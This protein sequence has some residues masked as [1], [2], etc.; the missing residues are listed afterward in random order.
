MAF[1]F[2]KSLLISIAI[3]ICLLGPGYADDGYSGPDDKRTEEA[4]KKALK[5]LGPEKGAIP[6]VITAVDI[7]GL[8]SV[9]LSTVSIEIDK[10]LKDLGA[11][12]VGTEI[13]ISLSGDVLFDFNKWD[14]KKEA[15]KTLI[16][17]KKLIKDLNKRH[18]IVEGHT[19]SK[20]SES[21]N[22]E[23]SEKRVKA[24]TNWFIYKG[25]S[26]DVDFQV[27]GCG[28]SKP[29]APNTNPDG[30]DNPEGRA[31]NRRVEIRII[32]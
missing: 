14:I 15:E 32:D 31:K 7:V 13:Q 11:R 12:K 17:I 6:I 5:L 21:Y 19:D 22:L 18:V 29:V 8:K 24:V 2:I 28:E 9:A 23:L 27:K 16:K 4:A 20:G 26:K 10:T 3:L 25:N 1:S 30:S